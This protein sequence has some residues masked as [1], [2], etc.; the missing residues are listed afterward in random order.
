MVENS[1][2]YF[3]RARES[4]VMKDIVHQLKTVMSSLLVFREIKEEANSPRDYS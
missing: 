1:V 4:A 3:W 2:Y